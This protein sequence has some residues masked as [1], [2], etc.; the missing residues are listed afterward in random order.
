MSK[1]PMTPS[2]IKVYFM[3]AGYQGYFGEIQ[4][5]LEAKQKYVGGL[6]QVITLDGVID[7]ICNDEGKLM[8]LP[9]NRAWRDDD[10]KPI[11]I[12]V[13]S[14]VAVR[15]DEEGNFIDIH[16]DDIQTIRKYLMPLT[17]AKVTHRDGKC[18]TVMLPVTE[19][20]LKEWSK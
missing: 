1:V 20:D 2:N 5:T 13:G 18:V 3:R 9:V 17:L 6:I 19:E 14:I 4:N 7:I 8:G 12:F 10:G 16:D 11:D 15:H